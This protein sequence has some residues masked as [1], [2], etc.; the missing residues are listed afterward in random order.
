MNPFLKDGSN[1]IVLMWDSGELLEKRCFGI[2]VFFG[3]AAFDWY[4]KQFHKIPKSSKRLKIL[5][6]SAH[7]TDPEY[8]KK[9]SSKCHLEMANRLPDLVNPHYVQAKATVARVNAARLVAAGSLGQ[10]SDRTQFINAP[11][12]FIYF[13]PLHWW[14]VFHVQLCKPTSKLTHSWSGGNGA[15]H[16]TSLVGREVQEDERPWRF[17]ALRLSVRGWSQPPHPHC[18]HWFEPAPCAKMATLLAKEMPSLSWLPG[19]KPLS[20]N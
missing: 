19:Y 15:G 18:R 10:P 1:I 8:R 4:L 17:V 13:I 5:P 12:H 9:A 11:C 2:L 16:V 3:V 20:L 6:F 14:G 7:W